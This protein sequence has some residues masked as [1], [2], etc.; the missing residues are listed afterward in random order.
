MAELLA[1]LFRRSRYQFLP[2]LGTA[3]GLALTARGAVCGLR[4]G[5]AVH[6]DVE[7]IPPLGRL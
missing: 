3:E 6:E 5:R 7:L 4:S 1:R 2:H